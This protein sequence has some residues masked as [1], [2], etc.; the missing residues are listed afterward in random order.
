MRSPAQATVADNGCTRGLR[1]AEYGTGSGYSGG[2]TSQ[3][4]GPDG[5][6]S[7]LDIEYY[8]TRWADVIH[9]EPGLESIRC[10]T[11][12]GTEGLHE[13]TP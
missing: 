13:R 11:T 10:P 1:V 4:V 2:L 6:V 9:H 12:D 3:L 7:N 8:P 5:E